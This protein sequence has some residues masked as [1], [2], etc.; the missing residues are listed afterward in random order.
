MA[1]REA[2]TKVPSEEEALGG[3]A[4]GPGSRSS[5][6]CRVPLPVQRHAGEGP[7]APWGSA[8]SLRWPP[9][10]GLPAP[11]SEGASR[12]HPPVLSFGFLLC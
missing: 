7:P 9:P 6:C 2:G 11:G 5:T 3:L 12:P 10:G 4:G 8:C 1:K